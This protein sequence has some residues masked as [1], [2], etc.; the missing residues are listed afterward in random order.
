MQCVVAAILDFDNK[1]SIVKSI[2]RNC[3]IRIEIK[4]LKLSLREKVGKET[5][6]QPSTDDWPS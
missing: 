2:V 3:R 4:L 6:H 1:I 5:T